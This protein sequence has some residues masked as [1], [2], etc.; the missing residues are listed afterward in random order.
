[1]IVE[2]LEGS[3]MHTFHRQQ[4]KFSVELS[5]AGPQWRSE[6]G[7]GQRGWLPQAVHF[8]RAALLGWSGT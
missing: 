3:R 1:M 2:V 7:G 4:K 6:G 5:M 8:W